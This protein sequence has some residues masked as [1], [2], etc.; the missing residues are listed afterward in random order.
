M[1]IGFERIQEDFL[2]FNL[3]HISHS[4]TIRRQVL[5][6]QIVMG[7]LIFVGSTSGI[8]LSL[9]Y[10]SLSIY[11]VVAIVSILATFAYPYIYRRSA[12]S[13]AQKMLKEGSNKSLLGRHEISLSS[14]GIIYKTFA[15]ESKLN[16]QSVE[17][18]LQNDKYVFI[19]I[20]AINALVVP[21]NTFASSGQQKEFLDY[22]NSNVGQV[23]KPS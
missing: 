18:V 11:I 21:K 19:Y 22:V 15:G 5:L 8:F 12:I 1:N 4:P 14:D 9:G 2:E 16:W 7:V 13:Q 3:F 23:A 10:L 6:T 17:K 20:G